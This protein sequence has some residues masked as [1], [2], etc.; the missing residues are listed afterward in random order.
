MTVIPSR[1]AVERAAPLDF[2]SART[3]EKLANITIEVGP[4]GLS[5]RAEYTGSLAS[6]PAA[7]ERLKA[8]GVLELVS[9]AARP[10]SHAPSAPAGAASKKSARVQPEYDGNGDACCPKHHKPLRAGQYGL[11]CPA[12]DDSTERGYCALKFEER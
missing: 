2:D 6:I 9:A 4:A 5:V 1:Q 7:I 3:S 10:A 11:F 12:K 8:A